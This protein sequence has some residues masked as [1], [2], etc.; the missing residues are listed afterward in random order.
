MEVSYF[1]RTAR[2][3]LIVTGHDRKDLLHRLATHDV[4]SL[5]PGKG[6]AVCFCTLKGRLIDWTLLLDRGGDLLLLT[7]N[8]ERLAGHILQYT[9]TEDVTVRNYI[10]V[11]IVVCGPGARAF[12]GVDLEPWCHAT[13][14]LADVEVLVARIEPLLG[15]AYAILAPDAMS[16]RRVLAEV[17]RALAPADVDAARIRAGIPS[18]PNEINEEHNPWEAG[19]DASISLHKGCY[20]G[21]EVIARLHTYAK[22]QRR[23]RRLRLEA[24]RAP[25]EPVTSGGREVG[26]L[27]TVA[28]TEALAYLDIEH[29]AP[30]AALDGARILPFER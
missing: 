15:E 26:R 28:G 18:W 9:I 23:L 4:L 12:V 22:V 21:Q 11:E 6:R 1:D 16:L 29:A 14:R 20:V 17:G 27:T 5:G 7:A 13:R 19:L 30:E 10:A 25:G 8:P 2:G 3:R 24:P